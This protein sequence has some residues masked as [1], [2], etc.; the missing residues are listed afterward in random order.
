MGSC[1]QKHSLL[2]PVYPFWDWS[3]RVAKDKKAKD[4]KLGE[5]VNDAF[6]TTN[7]EIFKVNMG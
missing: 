7:S 6:A 5:I 3:K 4:L 1:N 2:V